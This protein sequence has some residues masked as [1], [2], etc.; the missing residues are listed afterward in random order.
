MTGR[1]SG[2]RALARA[3]T[4]AAATCAVAAAITMPALAVPGASGAALA[5]V[6]TR[7]ALGEL[8]AA[9][10]WSAGRGWTAG[11]AH[12][13]AHSRRG[14]HSRTGSRGR[15]SAPRAMS[16]RTLVG[17]V[18]V[19][20]APRTT[21]R[22]VGTIRRS[23]TPVVISCYAIGSSVAG[24]AIWY[25]ISAPEHGYIPSNSTAT[26]L[27]PAPGVVKCPS[28]SRVYRTVV[29]GL[30]V[31]SRATTDAPILAVLR[32]VGTRVTVSC[33]RRG[34]DISGDPIWYRLV[35]PRTGYV[36]G[37]N[38]NTGWDPASGVPRC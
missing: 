12:P 24:N 3:L 2:A 25:Q 33:Y 36:A 29:S 26:H 20:T 7:P 23:G 27:D 34:Q 35:S 32:A 14:A 31:R 18:T 28:F 15:S 22:V 1:F 16:L 21:A 6:Q 37:I 30:H 19:R 17:H 8:A 38:L 5:A 13:L 11:R 4:T 10:A 9:R